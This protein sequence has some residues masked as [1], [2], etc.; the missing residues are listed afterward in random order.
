MN[1]LELMDRRVIERNL[2]KGKLSREEIEKFDA[3]LPDRESNAEPIEYDEELLQ[4]TSREGR[5][6]RASQDLD[7]IVD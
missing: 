5:S 7:E 1:E 3:A 4:A 2:Q 6:I